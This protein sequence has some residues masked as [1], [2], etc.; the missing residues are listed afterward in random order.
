M[1]GSIRRN[2]ALYGK[3]FSLLRCFCL[4]DRRYGIVICGLHINVF[5]GCNIMLF[6][7]CLY[8]VVYSNLMISRLRWRPRASYLFLSACCQRFIYCLIFYCL[9][10][11]RNGITDQIDRLFPF[12]CNRALNQGF[13]VFNWAAAVFINDIRNRRFNFY[14]LGRWQN[15][16]FRPVTYTEAVQEFCFTQF[17]YVDRANADSRYLVAFLDGCSI[18]AKVIV[19]RLG[20]PDVAIDVYTCLIS[21]SILHINPVNHARRLMHSAYRARHFH[22]QSH[23]AIRHRIFAAYFCRVHRIWIFIQYLHKSAVIFRKVQLNLAAVIGDSAMHAYFLSNLV[24]ARKRENVDS[25]CSI[26]HI[27]TVKECGVLVK[28][29]S[30]C[31][32]N[33][34]YGELFS[35]LCCFCLADCRHSIVICALHMNVFAGC[36]IML[37]AIYLHYIVYGNFMSAI[38]RRRP[39]AGYLFL[40]TCC[41]RFV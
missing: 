5:V 1:T 23:I 41:Q 31:R 33:A 19:L 28:A 12:V 16:D 32:N 36:N 2:N 27:S 14:L 24:I 17:V 30:V 29:G 34:F 6:A 26:L 8:H 39:W 11:H 13:F 38:L 22:Q 3:F 20:I 40:G 9:A 15:I 4:A 18:T 21:S 7:I 25:A 35:F 37:F 10:I